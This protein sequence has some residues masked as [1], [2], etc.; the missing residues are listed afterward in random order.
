MPR[1]EAVVSFRV[2]REEYA[3]IQAAA[4]AAGV[5]MSVYVRRA[6]AALVPIQEGGGCDAIALASL[7]ARVKHI[8]RL[9]RVSE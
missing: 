4:N 6:I 2:S 7:E 5:A 9:L 1:G 3:M 8:E